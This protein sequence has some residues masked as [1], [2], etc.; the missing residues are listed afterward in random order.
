M[1]FVFIKLVV[2]GAPFY[3]GGFSIVQTATFLTVGSLIDFACNEVFKGEGVAPR[4]VKL[5]V[6][7]SNPGSKEPTP[8][9]ELAALLTS[10]LEVGQPIDSLVQGWYLLAVVEAKHVQ[11][12]LPIAA[13]ATPLHFLRVSPN[14]LL[15]VRLVLRQAPLSLASGFK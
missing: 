15:F 10:R 14:S 6:A 5:Y 2:A 11:G 8:D 4:H 9:A 13:H 3:E 1:S 12:K 7:N